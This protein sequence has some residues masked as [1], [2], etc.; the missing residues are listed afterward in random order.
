MTKRR[1][2]DGEWKCVGS[3]K[4]KEDVSMWPKRQISRVDKVEKMVLSGSCRVGCFL[5][6]CVLSLRWFF[7]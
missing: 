7:F 5:S 3:V 6:S 4:L 2:P 1:A